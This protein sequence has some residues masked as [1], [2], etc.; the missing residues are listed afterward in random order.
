MW[1]EEPLIFDY[2]EMPASPKFE[3]G[4]DLIRLSASGITYSDGMARF[5]VHLTAM[6]PGHIA[7]RYH[8]LAEAFVLVLSDPAQRRSLTCRTVNDFVRYPPGT[9]PDHNLRAEPPFPPHPLDEK[10]QGGFQGCWINT[11]LS[12]RTPYPTRSPS[13]FVHAVLELATSNVVGLDLV[14]LQPVIY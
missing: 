13:L 10:P 4:K 1:F 9:Q 7:D 3:P 12:C 5:D 2:N 8:S 11:T 6:L 14:G